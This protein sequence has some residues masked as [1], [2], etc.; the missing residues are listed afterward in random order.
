MCN[1]DVFV[2]NPDTYYKLKDKERKNEED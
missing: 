1:H 2:D